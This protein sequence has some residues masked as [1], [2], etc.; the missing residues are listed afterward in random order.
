MCSG[1]EKGSYLRPIDVLHHLTLDLRVIKKKVKQQGRPTP[2]GREVIHGTRHGQISERLVFYCWKNS[3]S[4]AP[5]TSR[6]MCCP[7]H[8]A[9]HC[10]PCQPLLRAFSGWLRSPPP[11]KSGHPNKSCLRLRQHWSHSIQE[12]LTPPFVLCQQLFRWTQFVPKIV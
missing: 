10:A 5:C 7:A 1:S 8:C 12:G 4:T 6:R 3:A 2:A 9:S 11:T